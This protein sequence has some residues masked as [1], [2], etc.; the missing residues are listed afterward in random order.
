MYRSSYIIYYIMYTSYTIVSS[1]AIYM[2]AIHTTVMRIFAL[3]ICAYCC[4]YCYYYAA[5]A[6]RNL[7]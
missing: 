1:F 2:R 4:C 7:C 3:Y 6:I 5:T